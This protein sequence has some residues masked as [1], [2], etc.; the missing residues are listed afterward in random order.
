MKAESTGGRR[1][2]WPAALTIAGS[3]SGGGAGIQA[4]LKT[5]S[6][7]RVFGASAV[8]C[9]TAQNPDGVTGVEAVSPRLVEA[10]I[11]AVCAGFPV[12][13]AKTGMLYS[14]GI[15]RAVVRAVERE[16]IRRLVADPVMVAASG[17]RLLRD[18]ALAALRDGLLPLARVITPNLPEAAILLGRTPACVADL[19]DAARDLAARFG[20][21]CLLKGGH[22]DG[23]EIDD[24][25]CDAGRVRVFRH[26]R[27]AGAATH[28]AGC[29]FSAAVAAGLA[30]G[31]PLA[32]A[33][34]AA[35]AYV[36][37]ALAAALAVGRQR[38]L[39]FFHGRRTGQR[40]SAG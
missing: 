34:R 36:R 37:H 3:D 26:R 10:Q 16:G 30:H 23:P 12:A 8:T 22:L 39:H 24:V 4:D 11:R 7:F 38:P 25:L 19:P 6:A 1:E 15:V 20:T 5:F 18:D 9:V 27:V 17:A 28:G 14:A 32:D 29:S 40:R 31:G 33:V 21:A 35:Q 2:R 13:A